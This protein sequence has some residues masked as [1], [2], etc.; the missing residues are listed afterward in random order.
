MIADSKNWHYL[1]V[2]SL[3]AWL[4][5]IISNHSLLFYCLNCFHS[6]STKE[7]LE[8]H[9]KVCNEHDYCYVEMP[10]DNNKIL[11]FNHW[12][13]SLKA[14][15]MIYADLECLLEK[16]HSCQNNPENSYTEKKV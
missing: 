1:S 14:P 2:K 8:K 6:Y 9:G 13:K 4:R 12:E 15:I 16:M 3:P 11:R 5:W 7:K 10:N